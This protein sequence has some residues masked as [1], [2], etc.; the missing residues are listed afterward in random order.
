MEALVDVVTEAIRVVGI[1]AYRNDGEFASRSGRQEPGAF[2]AL[3]QGSQRGF[4]RGG[5]R[6]RG[7]KSNGV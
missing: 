3:R 7:A 1:A 6:A 5:E 4:A 2:R